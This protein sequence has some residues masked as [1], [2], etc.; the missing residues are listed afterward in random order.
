M[1]MSPVVLLTLSCWY[2]SCCWHCCCCWYFKCWW[3]LLC[4]WLCHVDTF[5][6]ADIVVVVDTLNVDES[7]C[8]VA[9]PDPGKYIVFGG[10]RTWDRLDKKLVSVCVCVCVNVWVI[11]FL[12]FMYVCVSF[13]SSVIT[14][15]Q[16]ITCHQTCRQH[17]VSSLLLFHYFLTSKLT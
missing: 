2:L 8:V 16:P 11:L 10:L 12:F 13:V 3:V 7:C 1:L 9:V 14:V 17:V 15:I 4:C 5:H 6:V